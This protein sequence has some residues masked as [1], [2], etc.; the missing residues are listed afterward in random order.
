MAPRLEALAERAKDGARR[1]PR[2]DVVRADAAAAAAI[3]ALLGAA[4]HRAAADDREDR[5]VWV[6]LEVGPDEV[7]E[8]LVH[9]ERAVVV[10]RAR[11][12]ELK[13]EVDV[14]VSSL[15]PRTTKIVQR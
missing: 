6:L 1:E 7:A 3:A 12:E 14:P 9:E 10:R 5:D 4:A 15:F 8:H 2:A 11:A 13:H